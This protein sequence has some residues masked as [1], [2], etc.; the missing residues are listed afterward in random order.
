MKSKTKQTI[1]AIV[2]N[3]LFLPPIYFGFVNDQTMNNWKIICLSWLPLIIICGGLRLYWGPDAFG[4]SVWE[5]EGFKSY[6]DWLANSNSFSSKFFRFNIRI[7]IPILIL[8]TVIGT[9]V[10]A[11]IIK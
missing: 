1:T 3:V 10:T 5:E 6:K 4:K 7:L 8:G 9:I 2:G 11:I